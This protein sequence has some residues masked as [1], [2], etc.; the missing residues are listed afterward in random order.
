MVASSSL[1]T[2]N[3]YE[4]ARTLQE[5]KKADP[6]VFT[7]T[8]GIHFSFLSEESLEQFPEIDAIVR[9]EGELARL[10]PRM[11]FRSFQP[12]FRWIGF[13]ATRVLCAR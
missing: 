1:A 5:A 6:G 2:C 8:G 4:V 9:G 11:G 3:T 13:S 7:V 12:W 10:S